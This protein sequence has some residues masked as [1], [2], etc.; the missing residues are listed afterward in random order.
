VTVVPTLSSPALRAATAACTAAGWARGDDHA[1][2]PVVLQV[3]GDRLQPA[4]IDV[5]RRAR[6]RSHAELGGEGGREGRDPSPQ[7]QAMVGGDA[8]DRQT[9][10]TA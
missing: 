1:V 6:R 10:S 8:G 9:L 4:S 2:A 3:A 7:P 5:G